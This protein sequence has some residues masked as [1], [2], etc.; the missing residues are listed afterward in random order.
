MQQLRIASN[1][2]MK[3]FYSSR[4]K[5]QASKPSLRFVRG[6]TTVGCDLKNIPKCFQQSHRTKR[7][8]TT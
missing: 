1:E 2:N 5:E 3:K 7:I 8:V 4:P 6:T